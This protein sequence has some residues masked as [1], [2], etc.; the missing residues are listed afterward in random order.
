M[1][2]LLAPLLRSQRAWGNRRAITYEMGRYTMQRFLLPAVVFIAGFISICVV[3]EIITGALRHLPLFSAVPLNALLFALLFPT[4]LTISLNL[5]G[6][7]VS[8]GWTV[9]LTAISCLLAGGFPLLHN[10][11]LAAVYF[12]GAA[13]FYT[14]ARLAFDRFGQRN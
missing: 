9:E 5:S 14:T 7:P 1:T 13:L 10:P 6:Q 2:P 11:L 3:A 12:V 4:I 8:V